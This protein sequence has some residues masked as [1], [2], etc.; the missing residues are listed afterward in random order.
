MAE[1]PSRASSER[2]HK[3]AAAT[4]GAVGGFFGLGGL[5]MELPVT[6]V[7]MLRSIADIARS[8]NQDLARP[9]T[10][11]ACLE[12]FAL[13]GGGGDNAAETGYYAVRAALSQALAEAAHHIAQHGLSR[14]GAP[15][16]VRAVA[17]VAAR[18]GVVVE[19]KV[20]LAS[21]PFLGAVT[22][23]MINTLFIDHFQK[24]ARGHFVV[25]RLEAIHGYETVREAYESMGRAPGA[26]A[27]R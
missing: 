6:T 23:S 17:A 19:Q 25:R 27:A 5:T 7:V 18:F 12:V 8:E 26:G 10:R 16:L 9:E 11:L 13:G 22:A 1:E 15:V 14:E 24:R 21:V 20:A 3:A 4:T 2:L